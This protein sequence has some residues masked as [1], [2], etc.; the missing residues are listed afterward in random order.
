[1]LDKKKHEVCGATDMEKK[2]TNIIHINCWEKKKQFSERLK[3]KF[4]CASRCMKKSIVLYTMYRIEKC[5]IKIGIWINIYANFCFQIF[6][7]KKTIWPQKWWTKKKLNLIE[8]L[9][10]LSRKKC[11]SV[12]K[13]FARWKHWKIRLIFLPQNRA[14]ERAREG[15]ALLIFVTEA[16]VHAECMSKVHLL[17][18][19]KEAQRQSERSKVYAVFA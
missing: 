5:G 12:L 2:Q 4:M 13:G 9:I 17:R 16:Y 1:M 14:N 8:Q 18:E 3:S 6:R 10:L 7:E 15:T 11:E 19:R